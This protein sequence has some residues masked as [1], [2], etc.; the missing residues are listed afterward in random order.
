MFAQVKVLQGE[1]QR[2]EDAKLQPTIKKEIYIQTTSKI[3][4]ARTKRFEELERTELREKQLTEASGDIHYEFDICL[5]SLL[6]TNI[7]P[8]S[9]SALQS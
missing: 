8:P 9:L 5:H 4:D 3:S 6:E 1:R 7:Q 2:I